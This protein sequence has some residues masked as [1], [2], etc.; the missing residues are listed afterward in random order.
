MLMLVYC[1]KASMTSELFL[2]MFLALKQT[3]CFLKAQRKSARQKKTVKLQRS[4]SDIR[5][6]RGSDPWRETGGAAWQ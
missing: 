6:D 5:V 3:V 1:V 2:V 4:G